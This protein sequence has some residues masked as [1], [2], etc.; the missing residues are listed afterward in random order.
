MSAMKL[1]EEMK[2]IAVVSEKR[3]TVLSLPDMPHKLGCSE[4]GFPKFFVLASEVNSMMRNLNAELLFVE[5]DTLCNI[6][7]GGV[8]TDNIKFTINVTNNGL[9]NATNVVVYDVLDAA[10][11]YVSGGSYDEATRNVTWI[12]NSIGAGKSD[13]VSVV[14][15]VLTN[16]SFANVVTAYA[17]ENKTIFFQ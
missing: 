7:E 16:G 12:I 15:S 17:K 1:F 8:Q 14:V 5:Y 4:E 6:L 9:S 10:F 13:K 11:G 3:Y 2:N